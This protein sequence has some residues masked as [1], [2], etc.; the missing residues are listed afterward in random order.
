MIKIKILNNKNSILNR[1]KNHDRLN[2]NQQIN[3]IKKDKIIKN[4]IFNNNNHGVIKTSH[5]T[6]RLDNNLMIIL[7]N[8]K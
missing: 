8:Q 3:N 6:S 4:K 5:N 2:N 1:Q 7:T